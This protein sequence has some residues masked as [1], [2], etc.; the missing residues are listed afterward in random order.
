[1]SKQNMDSNICRKCY[2]KQNKPKSK[3]IAKIVYTAE[4]EACSCCGRVEFL[5]D[6]IEDYYE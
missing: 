2:I 5:V 4:R 1:M 3:E 6:Y